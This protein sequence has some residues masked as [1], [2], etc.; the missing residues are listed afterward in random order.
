[1]HSWKLV[2][3]TDTLYVFAFTFINTLTMSRADCLANYYDMKVFI[4]NLYFR[5]LL[6][7]EDSME[8]VQTT[9]SPKE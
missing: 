7:R 9:P 2:Y 1:M 4:F 5:P 6:N 8:V 3:E